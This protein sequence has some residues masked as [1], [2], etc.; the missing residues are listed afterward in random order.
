MVRNAYL[1]TRTVL[2]DHPARWVALIVLGLIPVVNLVVIGYFARVLRTEEDSAD[3]VG[4]VSL[5]IGGLRLAVVS[6]VYMFAISLVILLLAAGA[7]LITGGLSLIDGPFEHGSWVGII[8]GLMSFG[9]FYLL[10][11]VASAVIV[12]VSLIYLMSL[13]RAARSESVGQAFAIGDI[14]EQIS[15][16][17]WFNY[18]SALLVLNF[19]VTLLVYFVVGFGLLTLGIGLLLVFPLLPALGVFTARYLA[20]IYDDGVEASESSEC[21]VLGEGIGDDSP[22]LNTL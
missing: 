17:G 1:Y 6:I 16:I 18:L 20:Q 22:S 14:M 4:V 10:V 9:A 3:L 11:A 15:G 5:F 19:A 13:V 2:A 7:L 12:A 21:P 8:T